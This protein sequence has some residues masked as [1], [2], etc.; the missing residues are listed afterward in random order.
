M[1][2]GYSMLATFWTL[3]TVLGG[4]PLSAQPSP[5]PAVAW[6]TAFDA[7]QARAQREGKP[8]L[9]LHMFGRLD[10]EFC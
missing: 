7:A 2:L 9:L 6:E 3:A 5:T 8:I 10:D 4:A 1:R